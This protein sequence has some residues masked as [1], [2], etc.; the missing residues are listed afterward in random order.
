MRDLQE[1][2]NALDGILGL[3]TPSVGIKLFEKVEDIPDTYE[4]IHDEVMVCQVIGMAR[5]QQKAVA[6]TKNSAT[7]CA[8]GGASVGLYPAPEE[9]LD[10]T[11]NAGIWAEDAAAVAKL[12][13]KRQMVEAG[14]VEAIGVCPLKN[15]TFEPDV[16]Q[17][18]GTPEQ[19][20]A[21]VYAH[22]WDGG[23]KIKLETNGHGASCN[24]ALSVPYLLGEVRLALADIGE[25]RCAA[26]G[27]EVIVGIPRQELERMVAL[28][29]HNQSTQYSYPFRSYIAPIPEVTR[30]RNSVKGG[31]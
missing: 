31:K 6:A 28:I 9:M 16:V 7:G 18:F 8:M 10:G 23:E 22:V 21:C 26:A 30:Q 19:A 4:V 2:G 14:T 25:R 1:M 15:M 12:M 29:E 20:L 11:R 27:Q 5:F 17:I 3:R 24:E 13:E